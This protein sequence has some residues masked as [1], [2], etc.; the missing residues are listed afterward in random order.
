VRIPPRLMPNGYA[1]AAGGRSY[2]LPGGV[3]EISTKRRVT[4]ANTPRALFHPCSSPEGAG[5]ESSS[6]RVHPSTVRMC[7]FIE[8]V[9][10]RA[11]VRLGQHPGSNGPDPP[12]TESFLRCRSGSLDAGRYLPV[13]PQPGR[14]HH[15]HVRL[16]RSASLSARYRPSPHL[17]ALRSGSVRCEL[18]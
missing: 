18:L 4:H 1:R 7:D 3:A 5:A 15:R 9:K 17:R 11:R 2:A 8:D 12:L 16:D 14:S 13:A 10:D 6:H